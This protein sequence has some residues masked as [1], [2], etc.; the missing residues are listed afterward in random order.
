M[1]DVELRPRRPLLPLK[2]L[3]GLHHL[4]DPGADVPRAR[5]RLPA[6]VGLLPRAVAERIVAPDHRVD[7]GEVEGARLEA[8]PHLGPLRAVELLDG[9]E[10]SPRLHLAELLLAFLLLAQR[11]G[12][13]L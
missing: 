10:L 4:V 1:S 3:L 6:G 7:E 5:L 9:G 11:G 8:L 12:G 13:G 2:L